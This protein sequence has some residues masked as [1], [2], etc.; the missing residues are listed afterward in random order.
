MGIY[1]IA[2]AVVRSIIQVFMNKHIDNMDIDAMIE[3]N[4]EKYNEK[5]QKKAMLITR[6]PKADL[7]QEITTHLYPDPMRKSWRKRKSKS[8]QKIQVRF[9]DSKRRICLTGIIIQRII[10]NWDSIQ[11]GHRMSQEYIEVTEIRNRMP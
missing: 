6:L 10:N 1:W 7:P 2:S 8:V 3:K 9:S 4:M 5:K 11:K